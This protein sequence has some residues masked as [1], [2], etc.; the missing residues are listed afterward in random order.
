MLLS[1]IIPVYNVSK[2]LEECIE[3][4]INQTLK[5][6]EIILVNDCSPDNNDEAI[7]LNYQKKDSRIKYI[8][9]DINKGVSEARN[10]GLKNAT[11]KYI[12]FVDGDDYLIDIDIYKK[13]INFLENDSNINFVG[14]G[15][16]VLKNGKII[17]KRFRKDKK[18]RHPSKIKIGTFIKSISVWAK[19]FRSTDLS[20]INISFLP[21]FVAEDFIF[22]IKYF[23]D[24]EP[25]YK[26]IDTNAYMYRKTSGSIIDVYDRRKF[27]TASV[28]I[29]EYVEE[30]NLLDTMYDFLN[31]MFIEE[32]IL[33]SL[34]EFFERDFE[35]KDLYLKI[36]PYYRVNYRKLDKTICTGN[37]EIIF[38]KK[39][40]F[41]NMFP[42]YKFKSKIYYKIMNKFYNF[43]CNKKKK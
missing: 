13:S 10:T 23:H 18:Y 35:L 41:I 28:Y 43:F 32:T 29:L 15:H 27:W 6:I 19:I 34:Y 33:K 4:I 24:V 2:Y 7:C 8:K 9:H 42:N 39:E 26:F 36:L 5:D 40:Q 11:G 14:F 22:L 31:K 25:V 30:N 3:S 38:N 17:K 37:Y 1:V 20:N 16:N 21:G 12:T